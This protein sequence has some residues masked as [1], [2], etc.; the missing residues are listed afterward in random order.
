MSTNRLSQ[1]L[2]GRRILV[3]GYRDSSFPKAPW[4]CSGSWQ[5]CIWTFSRTASTVGTVWFRAGRTSP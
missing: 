2:A 4:S 1:G 3:E 5:F